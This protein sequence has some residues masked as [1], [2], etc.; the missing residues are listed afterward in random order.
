VTKEERKEDLRK[1]GGE[2]T[3]CK[4]EKENRPRQVGQG[5]ENEGEFPKEQRGKKLK[6]AV[7]SEIISYSAER[8]K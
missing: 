1:N 5:S 4:W 3:L 7:G 6:N 2:E 8:G